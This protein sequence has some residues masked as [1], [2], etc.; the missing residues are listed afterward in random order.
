MSCVNIPFELLLN[1]PGHDV[2]EHG[3]G[4]VTSSAAAAS[5]GSRNND[6]FN[7]EVLGSDNVIAF[8]V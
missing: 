7:N 4:R 2:D 3:V 8:S 5:V 1:F 6:T